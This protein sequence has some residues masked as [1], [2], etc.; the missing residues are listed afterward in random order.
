MPIRTSPFGRIDNPSY[1]EI[2]RFH[3]SGSDHS[4]NPCCVLAFLHAD[5][6]LISFDGPRI[7]HSF[8]PQEM[9]QPGAPMSEKLPIKLERED[10]GDVTVLRLNARMLHSDEVTESLF[11]QAYSV[12]DDDNRNKVILN[13]HGVEFLASVAIGKLLS[14]MRKTRSAG[15]TL[16]LCNVSKSVFGVLHITKLSDILHIYPDEREALKAFA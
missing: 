10:V 9:D 12:V 2:E 3:I 13:L 15:G 4:I 7:S 8:R 6:K 14:L 5:S 11:A 1:T 16:N